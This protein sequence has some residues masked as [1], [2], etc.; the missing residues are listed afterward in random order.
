MSLK[1]HLDDLEVFRATNN[2]EGI[3]NSC[4][5]IGEFYLRKGR[6]DEAKEYLREA[7]AIC[8]KLGNEE[9]S[10][11]TAIGLG[12]IYRNV[13]NPETAR[14]HYE[15]AIDFFEKNGDEKQIANLMERLG[16]LSRDQGNLPRALEAFSRA[17]EI[18]QTHNDQLGVAHF[19]ERMALVYRDQ[20]EFDLAIEKFEDA[21]GYY[22]QHRVADRLAFVL[23]G[24][25]ELQYKVGQPKKGLKWL[26]QAL[27]I[28]QKLGAR[29]PAELVA[30]EI[31]A[32]EA[33]LEEE[34]KSVDKR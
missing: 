16:E 22:E 21:S 6:W 25:G 2:E 18:C 8:G 15:Q 4:F 29:T 11:I 32:I 20:E 27:R 17:K 26:N 12:D 10:A 13:D 34:K 19:N 23:T 30:A 33:A 5:K 14:T 1:K 3:A 24:L 28:Y 31:A 7:K 9:G